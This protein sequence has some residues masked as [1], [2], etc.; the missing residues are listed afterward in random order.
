MMNHSILLPISGLG[1]FLSRAE[2]H[3]D[4]HITPEESFL[5]P[6]SISTDNYPGRRGYS[7]SRFIVV[8]LALGTFAA[9]CFEPQVKSRAQ[10]VAKVEDE[11]ANPE[12]MALIPVTSHQNDRVQVTELA[13]QF[14]LVW[15]QQTSGMH[16]PVIP[17]RGLRNDPVE[18]TSREFLRDGTLSADGVARLNLS[19]TAS[20]ALLLWV[21]DY[22][23]TWEPAGQV[24]NISLG[25]ALVSGLTERTLIEGQGEVSVRS[26]KESFKSLEN[27]V[28][29]QLAIKVRENL[30][31]KT[32]PET[33][34]SS[35]PLEQPEASS[36]PP[37]E[38]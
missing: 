17:E 13:Q 30:I 31:P 14:A 11:V 7:M 6:A 5:K 22:G 35:K 10:S 37:Q 26:A 12:T 25:F 18:L 28:L 1:L 23:L 38:E 27:Q 33:D 32:P 36:I 3:T 16:L 20:Y 21:Q 2:K 15:S 19:G 34:A 4:E 29:T 8:L 24:K 9:G